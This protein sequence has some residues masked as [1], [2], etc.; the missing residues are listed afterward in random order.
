M[1]LL[2]LGLG[3][4]LLVSTFFL[5]DLLFGI[6]LDA[7]L[8]PLV[9]FSLHACIHFW[10]LRLFHVAGHLLNLLLLGRHLWHSEFRLG[11]LHL[12]WLLGIG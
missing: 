6:M 4:C 8:H 9:V 2:R 1:F 10:L 5:L 12:L 11:E 3:I 7:V